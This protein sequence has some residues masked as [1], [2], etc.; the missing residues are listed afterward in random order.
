LK[1][2][3]NRGLG[4]GEGEGGRKLHLVLFITSSDYR[5]KVKFCTGN[6]GGRGTNIRKGKEKKLGKRG[7]ALQSII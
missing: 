7:W 6:C 1:W 3:K 2:T 5:K 4:G